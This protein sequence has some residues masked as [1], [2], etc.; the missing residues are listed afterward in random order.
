MKIKLLLTFL[1]IALGVLTRWLPHTFNFTPVLAIS[2]FSGMYLPNKFA[3]AIPALILLISDAILGFYSG[4]LMISVYGSYVL[5]VGLGIWSSKKGSFRPFRLLGTSI[6]SAIIFFLITN[7]AV[8]FLDYEKSLTS[9]WEC[10]MLGLPFF[11][12]TV[13]S[14][15]LTS[16][17]LV[18][19]YELIAPFSTVFQQSKPS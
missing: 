12:A 9:L 10:Y 14:T 2:L 1:L 18:G 17:L 4:M 15:V 8:W 7:F 19:S 13:L 3:F 16:F 11:R 5:I 6:S